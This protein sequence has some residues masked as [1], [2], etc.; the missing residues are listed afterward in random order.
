MDRDIKTGEPVFVL[1]D[2]IPDDG[3]AKQ[4]FWR[5][6]IVADAP[7]PIRAGTSSAPFIWMTGESVLP[8]QSLLID[9]RFTRTYGVMCHARCF[10]QVTFLHLADGRG[11]F[12][13]PSRVPDTDW[14][15][16]DGFVD[17]SVHARLVCH[18]E[19]PMLHSFTNVSHSLTRSPSQLL[20]LSPAGM[21]RGA[22]WNAE[23]L[24]RFGV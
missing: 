4:M 19:L 21:S 14:I 13:E 9:G 20:S 18:V 12:V 17:T 1:I 7:I 23:V 15:E 2:L 11:W 5:F 10:R 6:T 16:E 22:R 3:T 24:R 8:N